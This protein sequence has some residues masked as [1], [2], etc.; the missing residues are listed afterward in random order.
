LRVLETERLVLREMEADDVDV[1]ETG[2][3]DDGTMR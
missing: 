3:G 2:L 1:P